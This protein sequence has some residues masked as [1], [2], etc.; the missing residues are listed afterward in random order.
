MAKINP[1]SHAVDAI[2]ALFNGHFGDPS[3]GFGVGLMAIL[4]LIALGVASRTF[5]R[6]AA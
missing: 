2:R 6:S 3:V 1:L 4:A 5:G